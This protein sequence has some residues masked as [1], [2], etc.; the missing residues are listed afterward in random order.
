MQTNVKRPVRRPLRYWIK[1]RHNPQLET[2]YIACGPLTEAAAK[3][4]GRAI[5]GDNVMH[6]FSTSDQYHARLR[7]LRKN[8]ERVHDA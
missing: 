3:R 8:G 5:F 6:G 2:Y 4:R 1:E 7:L